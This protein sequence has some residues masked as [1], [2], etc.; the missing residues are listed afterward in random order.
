MLETASE[1]QSDANAGDTDFGGDEDFSMDSEAD[2]GEDAEEEDETLLAEPGKRNDMQW[3]S[4]KPK[5]HHT[6]NDKGKAY[7]PEKHDDREQAGRRKNMM[8]QVNMEKS[9]NTKR[10]VF[11]GLE[12]FK[13]LTKGLEENLG[14]TYKSELRE[15]TKTLENSIEI[16]KIIENLQKRD[17][18]DSGKI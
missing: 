6:P 4:Q 1:D 3:R 17:D 2:S 5:P 7:I 11:P 16:R 12:G 10:N 13:Q 9:K 14:D 18:D 8:G 15:E